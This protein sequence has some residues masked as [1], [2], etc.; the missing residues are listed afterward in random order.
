MR[1]YKALVQEE[2][3]HAFPMDPVEQLWGAIEAV[4]ESWTRKKAVDYRRVNGI[5]DTLGTAVN[6]VAMVFGNM[7]DDSG[8]G[9]AFTRDPSTGERRSTASSWSTRRARTSW[10][11]SARRCPSTT[12]ASSCPPPTRELERTARLLERHFR[13]MQDI[14]FTVERG[15]AVP[16]ADAHAASARGQRRVRIACDMV[17]EGD[18]P[19]EEAV[20]RVPPNQLDQLLHPIIDPHSARDLLATGLPAS[21]GAASGIARLRRRRRRAARP[22]GAKPSSS[23]ATRPRPRTSTAWSRRARSSRRAAA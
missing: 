12:L 19:K 23:C 8:T 1:E 21:P 14:E 9:V 17:D 7:G 4:F 20:S 18:H 6:I 3:G 16:A 5:P 2:T 15:T 11:A 13:D 22:R 10:P